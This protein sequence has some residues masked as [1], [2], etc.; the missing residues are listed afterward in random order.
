M[1]LNE[2]PNDL[3]WG[4]QPTGFFAPTS[5]YGKPDDLRY[6]IEQC[7]LNHVGVI[8]DFVPVHFAIDGFA[9][10]NFDG[11]P[12]YNYPNDAVCQYQCHV[13]QQIH[14]KRFVRPPA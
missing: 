14:R 10:N 7:H 4:Y 1:P 12:L 13:R 5:R 2:Y 6:F 8:L 11:T 9:L 3:S